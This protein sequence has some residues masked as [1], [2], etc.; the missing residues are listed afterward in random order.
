M[1][2]YCSALQIMSALTNTAVARLKAVFADVSEKLNN[3]LQQLVS[4]V[5]GV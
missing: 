3:T 1:H 5:R 4:Y 2:N